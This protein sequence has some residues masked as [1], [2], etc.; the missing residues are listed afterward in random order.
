MK[1]LVTAPPPP[2][3]SDPSLSALLFEDKENKCSEFG[4][5]LFDLLA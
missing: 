5:N 2:V 3:L 1:L 4:W